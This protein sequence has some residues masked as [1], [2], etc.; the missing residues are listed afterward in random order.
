MKSN[1][2]KE[3]ITSLST[4]LD[5]TVGNDLVFLPDF[6]K[7]FNE[8]FKKKV[9]TTREIAYCEQFDKPILRYASTW[10]AKEAV[11]KSI[12]QL[13]DT[14]LPFNKIEIVREK[15]QGKPTVSLPV[16]FS[17]FQI[18]LSISHDG[19]Y[20]WVIAISKRII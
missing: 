20:V 16:L 5:L 9:F 13:S 4:G 3:F 6:E 14:S 8:L 2:V 11:Y 17:D 18:S 10:A 1:Q 12:K 19:S 7:S 15:I